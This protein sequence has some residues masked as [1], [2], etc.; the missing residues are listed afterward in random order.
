MSLCVL[1][2]SSVPFVLKFY[3]KEHKECTKG[4]KSNS[5]P[6]SLYLR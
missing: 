3:H 4:T 1:C 5:M 2:A 6:F